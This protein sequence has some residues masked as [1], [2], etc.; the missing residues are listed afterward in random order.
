M[1]N[2]KKWT[3]LLTFLSLILIGV[4]AFGIIQD[5]KLKEAN[6]EDYKKWNEKKVS[7]DKEI[8]SEAKENSD[9]V[10]EENS[11]G[12]NSNLD[13]YGK[14]KGKQDVKVLILGDG[15]A[16][17]EGRTTDKG[18][19]DKGLISWIEDT[20]GVKAELQSLAEK[21]ANA[22]RGLEILNANKNVI[23]YDLVITCFGQ[24]DKNL[25][26]VDVFKSNY[27]NIIAELKS[28]NSKASI[29]PILPST[30]NTESEYRLKIQEVATEN[31]LTVIDT[32][33][34]FNNAGVPFNSLLNGA[35]PNDKGYEQYVKE[36]GKIIQEKTK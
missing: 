29:V 27:N 4:L 19:W 13:F 11:T 26:N 8:S 10:P 21:G 22:A 12:R 17:G 34:A 28:R 33:Y 32:R 24:I 31:G 6:A 9:K 20:Y 35:L 18:L 25:V 23:D 5:K 15:L 3:V 30:I 36:I 16:V 2:E 7:S 14:L 1:K